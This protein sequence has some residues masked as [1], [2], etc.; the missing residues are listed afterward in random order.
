MNAIIQIQQKSLPNS[1]LE[2]FTDNLLSLK[3]C[4]KD[5]LSYY[6]DLLNELEVEEIFI[7]SEDIKELISSFYLSEVFSPKLIFIN[8]CTSNDYYEE[9]KDI[10]SKDELIIIENVG[11]IFNSFVRIKDEITGVQKNF[12]VRDDSF[13]ISYIKDHSKALCILNEFSFLNIKA[14][15]TL[16]DYIF[17]IDSILD[18]ID[19][20]DYDL[21]YS[22]IDGIVIGKNVKIDRSTKLI[23]PIIIQDNVNILSNCTIGPNSVISNNVFIEDN[24]TVSNT[25]VV[26]DTYIGTNLAFENKILIEDAIIDK[27]TLIKH[28]IDKKLISSNK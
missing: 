4:G 14:I 23:A 9:N 13:S 7:F 25:I 27:D 18:N 20:I 8:H 17:I 15:R 6:L 10:F 5:I 26:D 1:D 28:T 16:E 12:I 24:T 2:L 3:I 21:G 22:K 11:F 19:E